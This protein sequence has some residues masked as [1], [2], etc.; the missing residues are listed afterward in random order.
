MNKTVF[1]RAPWGKLSIR[2]EDRS[3][4]SIDFVHGETMEGNLPESSFYA[5][6]IDDPGD[7][8]T[9]REVCKQLDE[10]FAGRRK[11]F[12]LPLLLRGTP[13][14]MAV[15]QAMQEIPYGSTR[16]YGQLALSVGSPKAQ[17]AVGMACNRNPLPIVVPCHRVLGA[18]GQLTGYAG[19]LDIKV[20]LL[21]LEQEF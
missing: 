1:Y 7:R 2:I 12:D 3:L 13:F 14:Q 11:H 17:R 10:Y 16:S 9:A 6:E 19:G 4:S 5:E 8:E 18:Q 20:H 15:W 21:Q